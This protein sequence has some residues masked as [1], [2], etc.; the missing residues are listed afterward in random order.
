MSDCANVGLKSQDIG[1]EIQSPMQDVTY[2]HIDSTNW[3]KYE[4]KLRQL[5]AGAEFDDSESA[6]KTIS[7]DNWESNP[8]SLM[9]AIVKQK[10][11]DPPSAQFTVLCKNET[12]VAC[13]GC[14]RS[15]WSSEVLI[16]SVRTWTHPHYR[17]DWWHGKYIIPQQIEF[18]KKNQFAAALVTFNTSSKRMKAFFQRMV[19]GKPVVFG[20]KTPDVYKDFI[21]LEEEFYI[22]NCSQTIAYLTVNCGQ[23]HFVNYLMPPKRPL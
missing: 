18:A 15:D 2:L 11:F 5:C 17:D 21:L 23:D 14:Y 19:E 4:D 22:K 13:S 1:V 10:R 12:P 8:S 9:H 7:W 3:Q 6:Q 20:E 16:I